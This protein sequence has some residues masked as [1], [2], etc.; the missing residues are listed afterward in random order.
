MLRSP[1]KGVSKYEVARPHFNLQSGTAATSG[2]MIAKRS[3]N[4]VRA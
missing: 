4:S 2:A 3:A 1:D